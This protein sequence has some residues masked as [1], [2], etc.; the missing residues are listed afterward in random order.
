[1]KLDHALQSDATL[2]KP[3][4]K[5]DTDAETNQWI[6][7]HYTALLAE[8]ADLVRAWRYHQAHHVFPCCTFNTPSY[9]DLVAMGKGIVPVIMAE[10]AKDQR[11]KW[12]E[13]LFEIVNGRPS[14]AKFY[15]YGE[16]FRFWKGWFEGGL[17]GGEK[18][19]REGGEVMPPYVDE[20]LNSWKGVPLNG[21][22]GNAGFGEWKVRCG[23]H[24]CCGGGY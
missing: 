3:G 14:G 10:Y 18:G 13:L 16:M 8:F 24:A 6:L 17:T 7:K 23:H 2:L 20:W 12:H 11:G 15:C 19:E 4:M 5:G 22:E 1:M 9:R 21:V